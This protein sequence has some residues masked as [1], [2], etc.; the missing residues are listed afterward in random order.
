MSYQGYTQRICINGHYGEEDCY[1]ESDTCYQCKGNI[2]WTNSV[3]DTNGNSVGIVPVDILK[4]KYL[5]SEAKNETCNLGHVHQVQPAVFRIPLRKNTVDM[6]HYMN[7]DNELVKLN[8]QFY[9]GYNLTDKLVRMQKRLHI[10]LTK[11]GPL[12]EA[13]KEYIKYLKEQVEENG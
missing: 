1:S 12:T 5:I 7:D 10:L 11:E 8:P 6:Q 2:A 9:K 3:D 4:D 13:E